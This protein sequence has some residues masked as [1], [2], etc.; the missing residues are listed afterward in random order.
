MKKLIV[1]VAILAG[2]QFSAAADILYWQ[3]PAGAYV[4]QRFGTDYGYTKLYAMVNGDEVSLNQGG[5][6]YAPSMHDATP[7]QVAEADFSGIS[8]DSFFVEYYNYENQVLGH[9]HTFSLASLAKSGYVS[10]GGNPP[11]VATGV[12]TPTFIIPEPTSGMLM[13]LG[14]AGLALRRKRA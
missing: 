13:L 10:A 8:P 9:S 7:A 4:E 11:T 6:S 3:V 12:W 14:F 1:A 2:L 5:W